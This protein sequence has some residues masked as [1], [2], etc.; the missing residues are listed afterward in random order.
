MATSGTYNFNMDI[1]EVIQ[2]ASEMIG[3]ETQLGHEPKSA[4]RSINLI[5]TEWQNKGVHLWTV[6]TTAVTV[7]ASV[8]T[9]SL[10]SNTIDVLEA[11]VERSSSSTQLTRISMEEYLLIPNKKQSGRP[12]QYAVRRNRDN[13]DVFV[14]PLPENSTDIIHFEKFKYLEDVNK[15]AVQ[16]ADVPR[17]FLPALTTGL[18]FNL[19]IKRPNVPD[20][21]IALLKTQYSDRL[22]EAM[23]ED[24]ERTS[25]FFK[26]KLNVV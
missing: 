15:S 1:D 22:K 16:N 11:V 26:P 5:L 24:R 20:S 10:S 12:N 7:A 18:A 3:G 17:R 2:E 14:W 8:S 9:Y 25:L 19:A 21:R 4:R 23:E 6:N 13:P